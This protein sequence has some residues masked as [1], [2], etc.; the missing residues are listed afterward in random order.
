MYQKS[1]F[2]VISILILASMPVHARLFTQEN[3]EL[4]AHL[5]GLLPKPGEL[6]NW[7]MISEPRFFNPDN[8]FEYIDGAAEQYLLYG[9]RK[10]IT[11]EY[12]VEPDSS[13]VNIEIYC[14]ES[15]T[16]AFGIFAAER[17]PEGQPVAIGVQGHLSAN[18]LNFYKGPYYVKMTF[19]AVSHDLGASLAQMGRTIADKI[20]G[21]FKEPELFRYFPLEN[22]VRWSERYIP[23]DFLGQS[24]LQNGYRCD[25]EDGQWTYQI[26]LVPLESDTAAQTALKKYQYFLKSQDYR[27]RYQDDDKTVIAEKENFILLFAFRSKFGGVLNIKNLIQGQTVIETIRKNLIK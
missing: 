1:R 3:Q 9:F 16:H 26:F 10:V 15:P 19:F 21:E 27:I 24:Y 13:S 18:V 6:S 20:P 7:R 14:M 4:E 2:I 11:T 12:A 17:T 22:K 5:L 23:N 25:Y 8:L